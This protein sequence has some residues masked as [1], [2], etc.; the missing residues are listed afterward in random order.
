MERGQE[1][2]LIFLQLSFSFFERNHSGFKI[3]GQK[4][5]L[6]IC[7]SHQLHF[8]TAS[9][10]FHSGL[11][12]SVKRDAGKKVS[13]IPIWFSLLKNFEEKEAGAIDS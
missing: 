3:R 8:K 5:K 10:R 11:V 4:R 6:S 9:L 2:Q 13:Y 1:R 7:F 12:V